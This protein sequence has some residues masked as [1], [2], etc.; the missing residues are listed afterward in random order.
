M[1]AIAIFSTDSAM[2][3]SLEQLLREDLALSIVGV[4]GDPAAI[5]LLF[6]QNHVNVVLADAPPCEQLADWRLRHKQTAF[7]IFINGADQEDGLDALYAGARAILPRTAKRDEI[8]TAIKAVTK[9]LAV[10]PSELLP[11]LLSGA[12]LVGEPLDDDD[13]RK[14]HARSNAS[15]MMLKVSGS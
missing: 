9:G 12:S 15:V 14:S 4:A 13:A 11:S 1:V 5:S 10:L 6:D 3:R 2:C 8:V 7:V